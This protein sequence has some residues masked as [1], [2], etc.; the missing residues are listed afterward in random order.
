MPYDEQDLSKQLYLSPETI[1][2]QGRASSQASDIWSLGVTLYVLSTGMYPFNDSAEI[3]QKPVSWPNKIA[4][5][6]GF[7]AM[8]ERMLSKDHTSR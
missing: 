5:S 2:S 4:L 8:V 3:A 7:K 1:A 6:A